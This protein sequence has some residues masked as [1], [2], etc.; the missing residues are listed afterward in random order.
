MPVSQNKLLGVSVLTLGPAIGHDMYIDTEGLK[1]ALRCLQKRGSVKLV[2]RH[3][4]DVAD[5][6]GS[7]KNFRIDG[8]QIKGDAELISHPSK[9]HVMEAAQKL[10][11]SFGLSVEADFGDRPGFRP[12]DIDAIALV[13]RPAANRRGLFGAHL[14]STRQPRTFAEAVEQKRQGGSR[15]AFAAAVA[16]HP[17]LYNQYV[18][19]HNASPGAASRM[20]RSDRS[21]DYEFQRELRHF[22]STKRLTRGQAIKAI[23]RENPALYNAARASNWI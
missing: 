2:T 5:I 18:E 7:V 12:V 16:A 15:F 1:A 9:A 20:T 14:A 21:R 19:S 4:G 23:S 11:N 6:I 13:P 10:P 8:D 22:M 17:E 3:N